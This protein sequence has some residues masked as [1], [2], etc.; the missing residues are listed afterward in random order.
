MTA[1][2]LAQIYS[3]SPA[4]QQ[5]PALM[6]FLAAL[7]TKPYCSDDLGK[8]VQIRPRA[9]AAERAYIQIGSSRSQGYLVFD[10]DY[11]Y[12]E[13]AA[14]SCFAWEASDLPPPTITCIN[15]QNGHAHLLYELA[16][17][18]ALG[19]RAREHP[20]RWMAHIHDSMRDL[21]SADPGYAGLVTKNPLHDRWRVYCHDRQYTLGELAEW[22]PAAPKTTSPSHS[23]QGRNCGV[24]HAVR[25]W[26][27]SEARN[28]PDE[29]AWHAMVRRQVELAAS[30]YPD[31]LPESELRALTKSVARWTWRR[32]DS[33]GR[34][35]QQDAVMDLGPAARR[36]GPRCSPAEI[37]VREQAGARHTASS[38]RDETATRV[39][40]AAATIMA[41]GRRPTATAVAGMLGMSR[42]TA[43]RYLS[44]LNSV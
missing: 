26:A 2:A 34:G 44:D 30:S 37:R 8:G 27:Y 29:R 36:G 20:Q 15:P 16:A 31:M 4:D 3:T 22:L 6:R 13:A 32:R 23:G 14:F 11:D 42:Q 9:R 10:I 1:P 24:F 7:P 19:E 43:A 35:Q 5:H 18:V 25:H 40:E 33:L 12:E 28:A 39:R 38:R 21:L 41:A 17:P